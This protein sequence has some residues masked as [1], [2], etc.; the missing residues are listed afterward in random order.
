M[1]LPPRS[2]RAP[3]ESGRGAADRPDDD[4]DGAL[5]LGIECEL[6]AGGAL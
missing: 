3:L 6:L 4:D 2:A 1:S 5:V